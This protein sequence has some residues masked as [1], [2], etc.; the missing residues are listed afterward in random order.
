VSSPVLCRN[1]TITKSMRQYGWKS[2]RLFGVIGLFEALFQVSLYSAV[3]NLP[4]PIVPVLAQAM[5]LW[6]FLLSRFVLNK[7]CATLLSYAHCSQECYLQ[8]CTCTRSVTQP[9][10]SDWWQCGNLGAGICFALLLHRHHVVMYG[11]KP[12]VLPCS[13]QKVQIGGAVF[14]AI[15][16]SICA[17][18]FDAVGV[19]INFWFVLLYVLGQLVASAAA[20]LK[21]KVFTEGERATGEPLNVF[22]VN[23]G[24]STAQARPRT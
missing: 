20:I 11:G 19:S 2:K 23:F 14:V 12:L 9:Q 10:T 22:I 16:A 13:F 5:L 18:G 7:Q 6:N 4:G 3:A 21:E 8:A 15:G 1:G 17:G 24:G